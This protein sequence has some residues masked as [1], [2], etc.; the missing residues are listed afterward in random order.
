MSN[1]IGRLGADAIR[2]MQQAQQANAPQVEGQNGD[3]PKTVRKPLSKSDVADMM[4]GKSKDLGEPSNN[5]NSIV[6]EAQEAH[7][8]DGVGNSTA[9][10]YSQKA[11]KDMGFTDAELEKWFTKDSIGNYKMRDD[12]EYKY[13]NP[14]HQETDTIKTLDELKE[15][16]GIDIRNQKIAETGYP[17]ELFEAG[18]RPIMDLMNGKVVDFVLKE[19][20]QLDD[21]MYG[22]NRVLT[23]TNEDTSKNIFILREDGSKYEI[24]LEPSLDWLLANHTMNGGEVTGADVLN[25]LD[26]ELKLPTAPDVFNDIVGF[27][28][29]KGHA[30][31]MPDGK[32]IVVFSS[33]SNNHVQGIAIYNPEDGTYEWIIEP[34]IID[35]SHKNEPNQDNSG[36]TIQ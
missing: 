7:T 2:R 9:N 19:G 18:F 16:M 15:R 35:N 24:N 21:Q 23:L 4:Q 20:V 31:T 25:R 36:K 27:L 26:K 11:L 3:A 22:N 8:A 32:Q 28:G 30:Y 12:I 10:T 34:T 14:R 33:I 1:N 29:N 17:A 6:G 13:G 5:K